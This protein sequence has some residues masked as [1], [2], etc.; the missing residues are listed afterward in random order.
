MAN[1]SEDTQTQEPSLVDLS[2]FLPVSRGEGLAD[3][4]ITKSFENEG[5]SGKADFTDL[6]DF[7]PVGEASVDFES[8]IAGQRASA[9]SKMADTRT[10]TGGGGFAVNRTEQGGPDDMRLI[11]QFAFDSGAEK[12]MFLKKAFKKDQQRFRGFDVDIDPTDPSNVLIFD[13]AF[14][15]W[16]PLDPNRFGFKETLQEIGENA[17]L[18]TSGLFASTGIGG[19]IAGGVSEATRQTVKKML[20]PESDFSES[21]VLIGGL[22]GLVGGAFNQAGKSA[23][24]KGKEVVDSAVEKGSTT[25]SEKAGEAFAELS[26]KDLAKKIS[27]IFGSD[28]AIAREFKAP[29]A[30]FRSIGRKPITRN[31]G[32]LK[33]KSPEF[34]EQVLGQFSTIRKA[35]AASNLSQSL[36]RELGE[37]YAKSDITVS[38]ADI[39]AS[40]P[41]KELSRNTAKKTAD[42]NVRAELG[43]TKKEFLDTIADNVLSPEELTLYNS[44]KLKEREFIKLAS[45]REIP[46]LDAFEIRANQDFKVNYSKTSQDI[47]NINTAFKQR[48]DAMRE[49]IHKAIK[50]GAPI[51]DAEEIL[52]K[53]E[54]FHELIPVVDILADAAAVSTQKGFP[55]V[56]DV[57]A[58]VINTP[59]RFVAQTA[60]KVGSIP[61]VRSALRQGTETLSDGLGTVAGREA[62]EGVGSSVARDLAGA[63]IR[64]GQQAGLQT[65]LEKNLGVDS[66]AAQEPEPSPLP[67]PTPQNQQ[68]TE[69]LQRGLKFSK[70]PTGTIPGGLDVFES[71]NFDQVVDTFPDPQIRE[72]LLSAQT[73]TEAERIFALGTAK[74]EMRQQGKF[75]SGPL[76]NYHSFVA[77]P[78]GVTKQGQPRIGV[79]VNDAER[80][81]FITELNKMQDGLKR[82]E[83]KSAFNVDGSVIEIPELIKAPPAPRKP[84]TGKADTVETGDGEERVADAF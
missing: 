38:V 16:R 83:L 1:G 21:Q 79:I 57:F 42:R 33:E 59:A 44:G 28:A 81:A 9:V 65:T 62:V 56:R 75:Q 72:A 68:A 45:K 10:E 27:D 61:T 54:V 74:F 53:N 37:F 17:E 49:A 4:P 12:A 22:S 64:T 7:E 24:K 51:E 23:A 69:E 36:G 73:G 67:T 82:A 13:P 43:A 71:E 8:T 39:V 76:K 41:W 66:A 30:A 29:A 11:T 40:K 25:I 6:A 52:R 5:A 26:G 18:V 77:T 46:I 31:I 80:S 63:A 70:I 15:E 78:N 48:A 47:K 32:A 55:K 2:D 3:E 20:L 58:G 34:V 60:E 35:E 50:E 84:Q 14:Q 19:L